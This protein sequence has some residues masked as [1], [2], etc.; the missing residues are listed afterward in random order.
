MYI[1]MAMI[2]VVCQNALMYLLLPILLNGKRFQVQLLI[3]AR[4]CV[5]TRY[6]ISHETDGTKYNHV[7]LPYSSVLPDTS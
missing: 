6:G 4:I 1:Y 3:Q 7:I 2:K 5:F